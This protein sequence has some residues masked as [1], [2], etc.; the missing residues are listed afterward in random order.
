MDSRSPGRVLPLVGTKLH[1]P[2]L[3]ADALPRPRLFAALR[4]ALASHRLVLLSAPAGCGKTTLLAAVP[5]VCPDLAVAWLSLDEEDNDPVQFL[6]ALIA[7]LQ[8]LEP[9]CGAAARALVAESLPLAGHPE[10]GEHLRRVIG[11]LINDILATLPGPF[12]LLLDDLHRVTEPAVYLALDYLLERLPSQMRLVV[13]SH[14]DPP[15]AL[16]RLRARGQLAELR[17]RELRFT[18]E[19]AAA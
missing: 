14:H 4:E 1:I 8:R 3:P 10:P 2:S 16:A 15:L 19:E 7:S 5:Q 11:V 12:A 13:A 18:P 9:A 6:A 17:L